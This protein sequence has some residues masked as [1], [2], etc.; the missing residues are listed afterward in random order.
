MKE[1]FE[2][3]RK[4]GLLFISCLFQQIQLLRDPFLSSLLFQTLLFP[5]PNRINHTKGQQVRARKT[6]E[7]IRR[8]QQKT[9]SAFK[10]EFPTLLT[11]PAFAFT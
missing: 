3:K 4:I 10:R 1:R 5:P 9:K 8:R 7:E 6:G 11:S 2:K